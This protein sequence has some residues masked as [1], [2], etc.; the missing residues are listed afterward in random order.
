MFGAAS[1]PT[2]WGRYAA[3]LGRSTA[4][5]VDPRTLRLSIYVDDPRYVAGGGLWARAR[6]RAVALLWATL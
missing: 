4:G 6:E 3:W 1:A 5:L 2:V